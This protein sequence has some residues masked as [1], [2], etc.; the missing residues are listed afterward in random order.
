MN[1]T[2]TTFTSK[3]DENCARFEKLLEDFNSHD[4]PVN[5][6]IKRQRMLEIQSWLKD[7]GINVDV[8]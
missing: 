3:I 7:F 1:D 6:Y 4:D 2:K 8:P 5:R